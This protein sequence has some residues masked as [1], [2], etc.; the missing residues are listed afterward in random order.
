LLSESYFIRKKYE[1]QKIPCP[2][3]G[4]GALNCSRHCD[5]CEKSIDKRWDA[6]YQ[7]YR[8]FDSGTDI[9]HDYCMKNGTRNMKYRN[10][11]QT[12]DFYELDKELKISIYRLGNSAEFKCSYCAERGDLPFMKQHH[13]MEGWKCRKKQ[14]NEAN[15]QK[16]VIVVN[17]KDHRLSEFI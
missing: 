7:K 4:C 17:T 11:N 1:Q 15:K 14:W 10:R 6:D 2:V 5:N 13:K 3:A 12:P 16:P 9:P 8:I